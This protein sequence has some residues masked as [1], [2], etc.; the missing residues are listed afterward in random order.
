MSLTQQEIR[1]RAIHFSKDWADVSR[2]RAEAQTFWNEFFSV[3]GITRRRVAVYEQQ[4]QINGGK[5]GSIDLLWKGTLIAEHKSKGQDLTRAYGQALDYFPGLKETE[6]PRY[7]IVSDFEN[8]RL[9]DLETGQEHDF[10]LVDFSQHVHLFGFISG[11]TQRTYRDEDPVNIQVTEKMG[12]LHDALLDSGYRGHQ[13]EIF[14]VRLVYCLFADDTGIFSRDQFHFLI[15]EGTRDDGRDVGSTI[16]FIFQ[17]LDTPPENASETLMSNFAPCPLLM[18]SSLKNAW[19]CRLLLTQCA[20]PCWNAVVFDWSKVSPS[21]FGALF[22][23]VMDPIKRHSW[24]NTT[25]LSAT[26]S[27]W[28]VD[29]SWMI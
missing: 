25:P 9:Y 26:F 3:F 21:I 17:I 10:S 20:T 23:S 16:T 5:R 24:A 1:E 8:F 7:V 6:L 22:Q 27:R 4:V 29:Y 18:A 13:L 14:L 28:F 15:E 2:E 19:K 12:Q 11:Y